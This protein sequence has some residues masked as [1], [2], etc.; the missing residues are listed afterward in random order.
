MQNQPL[1]ERDEDAGGRHAEED[2]AVEEEE[3]EDALHQEIPLPPVLLHDD[4]GRMLITKEER[5]IA[6]LIKQGVLENPEIN[7]VSDFMCAQLAIVDGD[8]IEVSLDRLA[9]WQWVLDEYKIVRTAE[10]CVQ[11]FQKML[12][13]M[14]LYHLGFAY[15]NDGG[16]YVM[17]YD[18]AG[19]DSRLL[20]DEDNVI[21]W[22]RSNCYHC[23]VMNPDLEA[24]RR[25]I[26]LMLE[27]EGY[28]WKRGLS[29]KLLK[30]VWSEVASVQP[31]N[32]AKIKYF[33]SGVIMNLVISMLKPLI[34]KYVHKKLE[35]GCQFDKRLDELYLVPTV[36]HAHQRFLERVTQV[37]EQRYEN[38][39]TFVL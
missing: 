16:N 37:I 15:H 20:N 30:L 31:L 6:L 5:R 8:N 38:E 19:F 28:D 39:R 32:W 11:C 4:P 21:A 25:G 18:M 14:P 12:K 17:I 22:M 24:V 33:N 27:C 34:P 29:L 9:K 26:V 35:L 1:Q 7:E 3:E 23:D 36:G 13:I 2:D 10:D